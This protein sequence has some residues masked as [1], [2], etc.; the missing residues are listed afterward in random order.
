MADI[1]FIMDHVRKD[2]RSTLFVGPGLA[3]MG[4]FIAFALRVDEHEP[5][6]WWVES[7]LKWILG[8]A[9]AVGGIY[10]FIGDL[11]PIEKDPGL[12]ALTKTP[13]QIVWA[14]VLVTTRNG[15]KVSAVLELY[16]ETGKQARLPIP[17]PDWAAEQA[18]A[19]VREVAPRAALGFT[20]DREVQFKKDPASLRV[21]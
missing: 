18:L 7:I 8:G 4:I 15:Q 9:F 12:V 11:G 13:E 1:Q 21:A 14:H 6:L 16:L 17:L 19:V 5:I 20:P 2:R 10:A 3:V